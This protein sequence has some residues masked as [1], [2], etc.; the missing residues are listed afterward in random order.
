MSKKIHENNEV[1]EFCDALLK[2]AV[3]LGAS[4]IYLLP[5]AERTEFRC[6]VNGVQRDLDHV[7]A[8][9]GVQCAARFKVMAGML[10]YRTQIAQ[11]GAIRHVPGLG[12]V[13]FRVASMPTLCG[14][15]LTIRLFDRRFGHQLL[16]ELG[17]QAEMVET[18]RNILK[19]PSGL[20]ILTGPT[21]CGKTTTIYA[22]LRELLKAEQDPSSIITIEDP[23]ECEIDGVSQI[24]LPRGDA[25][26]NYAAALRAALRHDVKT[27]MIGEMRD[28]DVVKVAVDAALTGHRIITTYHAGDIPSVFARLLHQGF[29]PFL[30]ASAIS[31][32]AAQRLVHTA[33]GSAR[34][35]IAAALDMT[36]RWRDFLAE[37]PSS[38]AIRDM[39]SQ[40]P[41]SDL[42]Q[43]ARSLAAAGIIPEMDVY[44]L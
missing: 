8:P 36:D 27:L 6:R 12:E 41:G 25:E 7:P 29:E 3:A 39:I 31:G 30:I 23:V 26:W 9:F 19:R 24:S 1:P 33:D 28:R 32:V 15:R 4:D 21:G 18:L 17:F 37:A 44:L 42:D 5:G 13:E 43:V 40:T 20:I 35:P 14:E 16:D 22:M 38:A 34:I 2:R 10:S 11:D